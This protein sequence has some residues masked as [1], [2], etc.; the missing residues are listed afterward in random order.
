MIRVL[1]LLFAVLFALSAALQYNDPDPVQWAL[2]Y[3]AAAG[4]AVAMAWRA[5]LGEQV[6]FLVGTVAVLLAVVTFVWM[7]DWAPGMREFI[8]R[9]DLSL[10]VASMHAGDPVIEEGREFLGLAIVFVYSLCVIFSFR[11]RRPG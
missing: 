8:A 11:R 7:L 1:N 4:L 9:G 5:S 2:E 6:R 3:L 10:L